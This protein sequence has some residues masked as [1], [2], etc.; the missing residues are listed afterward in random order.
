MNGKET[1]RD[2]GAALVC[3]GAQAAHDIQ[4]LEAAR[5]PKTGCQLPPFSKMYMHYKTDLGKRLF[6]FACLMTLSHYHHSDRSSC[7]EDVFYTLRAINSLKVHFQKR[8]RQSR[9]DAFV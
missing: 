1:L 6:D 9:S 8:T 5:E 4:R 7:P 2:N 3:Q